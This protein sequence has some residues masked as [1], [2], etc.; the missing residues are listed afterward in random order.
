LR[1][2]SLHFVGAGF[3]FRAKVVFRHNYTI[4]LRRSRI[5]ASSDS[6]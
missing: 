1:D 4:L 3:M 6:V 2:A 5:S